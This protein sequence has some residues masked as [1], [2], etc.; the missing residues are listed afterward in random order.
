M[1]ALLEIAEN[2]V[3]SIEGF[4]ATRSDFGFPPNPELG[5]IAFPC[6]RFAKELRKAPQVLA[7]ELASEIEKSGVLGSDIAVSAEGPYVN[8]TLKPEVAAA[9]VFASSIREGL[10]WGQETPN[11]KGNW[12]LDY[13]SPNVAKPI[14]VSTLRSTAIGGAMARVGRFRG[15]NTIG[16]NH[17]GDWGTQYGKLAVAIEKF[18]GDLPENPGIKDLTDLYVKFHQEA[19]KDSS[20]EDQGRAAFVKLE[21]GD[22]KI[23]ELWRKARDIS[24]SEFKRVYKR[25]NV[26]FEHYWGESHYLDEVPK[27]IAELKEKNLL[28][29]SEG[30]QVVRVTDD[31]GK[32]IP[33]AIMIKADGSTI[34]ATRDVA[35][36]LYRYREFEFV[37]LT[38]VTG[39][40]QKLHFQQVKDV[41]RKMAYPWA[42][43]MEH[44]AFGLYRFKGLK[45][46]TRKGNYVTL[47]E[48]IE[49]AKE[50]VI[51]IMKSRE[52][53]DL[54]IIDKNAEA[55][56]IGAVVFYDLSVDPSK[57]VE[58]DVDKV[59]SFQGET[60]PYIQYSY[61][62]CLSI[63]RKAK[64]QL[65]DWP[66][67]VQANDPC[68]KKL[69]EDAEVQL[70]KHLS[71]FSHQLDRVVEQNKPSI[72]A[73]YLLDLTKKFNAFY[74]DHKVIV[75]DPDL[76]T[77]RL[78]LVEQ[79]REILESG[80]SLLG[81]PLP[82]RM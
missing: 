77:A 34:Y 69:T 37:R 11:S 62:R 17:I 14:L 55:I 10:K 79:T 75:D 66:L 42:E 51:E 9:T 7:N 76:R 38:W 22:E 24:L 44:L 6:F 26:E 45:M 78:A 33:P 82:E 48:V 3:N 47:E 20:L 63:L 60:G 1:E 30:A 21:Q 52:G 56:A 39:Q 31:K 73:T 16:I 29:E 53:A 64:E 23:L 43:K 36:C 68:L 72:L 65:T 58:F 27:V 25:M 61:T 80:L 40:E 74:K 46:S 32:E 18:G 71:W 81:V 54:S 2:A 67:P 59:V 5:D 28:E 8:F 49:L 13:S 15:Y 35:A 70:V 12:V 19:E 41:V 50:K 57:N 4:K